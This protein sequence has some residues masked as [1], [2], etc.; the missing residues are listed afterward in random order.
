MWVYVDLCYVYIHAHSYANEIEKN[1]SSLN[2][3]TCTSADLFT[4]ILKI[5]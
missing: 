1:S 5:P 4:D 3:A 2:G